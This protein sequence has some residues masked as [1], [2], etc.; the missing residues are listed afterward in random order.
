M[1]RILFNIGVFAKTFKM[2][3][4]FLVELSVRYIIHFPV[5]LY[6]LYWRWF[7]I[8]L[9]TQ[10][11]ITMDFIFILYYNIGPLWVDWNK[12]E[13]YWHRLLR[14]LKFLCLICKLLDVSCHSG[15][16]FSLSVYRV[17]CQSS[18]IHQIYLLIK[19]SARFTK[20]IVRWET[21]TLIVFVVFQ[22][23]RLEYL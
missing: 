4:N 14:I 21:T 8:I 9:M 18:N 22:M 12:E 11:F 10:S 16:Y 20:S 15:C 2:L 7:K 3:F 17:D 19:H 5:F 13:Y 6:R 23:R 1:F